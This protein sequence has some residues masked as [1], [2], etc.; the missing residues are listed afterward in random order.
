MNIRQGYSLL[1]QVRSVARVVAHRFTG[2]LPTKVKAPKTEWYR[3]AEAEFL[4]ERKQKPIGYVKGFNGDDLAMLSPQMR[5]MMSLRLANSQEVLHHRIRLL[6]AKFRLHPLDNTSFG[7][8]LSRLTEKILNLR[9]HLIENPRDHMRR[10]T[11][12]VNLGRRSRI[13]KAFYQKDFYG[14]QRVCRELRI[15][16]ARF[17]VPSPVH[18]EKAFN[19]V[20]VDGDRCKFLIRQKLWRG[21]HRPGVVRFDNR[22][23]VRYTRHPITEPVHQG[24]ARPVK[25]I[26]SANWP[27]AVRE[28]L[29]TGKY[30]LADPTAPGS[31]FTKVPIVL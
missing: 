1:T 8:T 14:Y 31:R 13:M 4:L 26:V 12:M 2:V 25:Q 19:N 16:C 5:T 10:V 18:H 28:A 23:P 15:R 17:A 6:N 7:V 3:K 30:S 22:N 24:K 9:R 11:M 20:A 29:V 27:Y 21:R